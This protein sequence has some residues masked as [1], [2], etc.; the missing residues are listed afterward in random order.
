MTEKRW[1]KNPYPL[2]AHLE[3]GQVRFAFASKAADCGILL[4]DRKSGKMAKKIA[5]TGEDRIGNIYCKMV[6]DI[7]AEECTYLFYEED[8]IVPDERGRVFPGKNVYRRERTAESF[9][10]GFL[11]DDF[12][13]GGT[14]C[15]RIPYREMVGYC[16]HVRG[17]TRHASSNVKHRGTFAGLME[18][19]P[20]LK[21]IGVTTVELQPAYEFP[22]LPFA[23]ERAQNIPYVMDPGTKERQCREKPENHGK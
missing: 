16:L 22:E 9:K 21:E 17:F 11:T 2:G 20:Y 14:S 8:R 15:P 10:A 18:K 4:Y 5:F 1:H 3:S 23:G 13:W 7:E 12:D 6:G 19:I